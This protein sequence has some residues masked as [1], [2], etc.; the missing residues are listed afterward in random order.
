MSLVV[1]RFFLY[2]A[3]R[4]RAVRAVAALK[5]RGFEAEM[6][7]GWDDPFWNVVARREIR[8][9][10]LEDADREIRE[11]VRRV[12]GDYGGFDQRPLPPVRAA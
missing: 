5:A 1:T 7:L 3:D 2:F 6:G 11:F 12:G 10:D 8:S 4:H 9:D